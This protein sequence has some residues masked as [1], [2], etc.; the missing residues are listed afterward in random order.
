MPAARKFLA[1][2]TTMIL[3]SGLTGSN[4]L[5]EIGGN[6]VLEGGI[7]SD[8]EGGVPVLSGGGALGNGRMHGVPQMLECYLQLAGRA[9]ER[10]RSGVSIGV[11]CHSSPHYGGV[12]AYSAERF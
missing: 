11:A 12:V 8:R 9:G 2:G 7:D 6:L 1:S 10:Q 4:L 5:V 3:S